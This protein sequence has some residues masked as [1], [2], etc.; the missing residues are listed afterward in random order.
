MNLYP[1]QPGF[2]L[3]HHGMVDSEDVLLQR[4][5]PRQTDLFV[6]TLHLVSA[7]VPWSMILWSLHRVT[8]WSMSP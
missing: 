1:N 7:V 4:E 2:N 8:S 6:A 5:M 3:P